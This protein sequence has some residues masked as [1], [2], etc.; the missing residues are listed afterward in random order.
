MNATVKQLEKSF[1]QYGARRAGHDRHGTSWLFPDGAEKLIPRNMPA[2]SIAS[3]FM[4]VQDRYGY[5]R[6]DAFNGDRVRGPK[7]VIDLQRCQ[8]SAHAKDRLTLMQTQQGVG[9]D[10][11]LIALRAPSKVLWSDKHGSWIWVGDRVAVAAFVD[12]TGYATIG[13]ILWTDTELW[14]AAPRPEKT[15]TR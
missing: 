3:M 6:R 2:A 4:W 5:T 12:E 10:E 1:R 8:A 13:T 11:V 7:P 14:D 9:Y 15:V